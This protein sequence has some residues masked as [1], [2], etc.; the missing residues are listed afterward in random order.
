MKIHHPIDDPDDLGHLL[1]Q[2]DR[3][4]LIA[5]AEV[6]AEVLERIKQRRKGFYRLT[7]AS[8]VLLAL[9]V[10]SLSAVLVNLG[11]PKRPSLAAGNADNQTIAVKSNDDLDSLDGLLQQ[12]EMNQ[13]RERLQQL[14][15]ELAVL[16]RVYQQQ[17]LVLAGERFSRSL[18]SQSLTPYPEFIG[19]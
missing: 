14:N 4:I 13:A 1:K 2:A 11:Q 9:V 17:Q 10:V 8:T 5:P 16:D 3:E 15:A 6:A 18:S 7:V 12:F 19:D